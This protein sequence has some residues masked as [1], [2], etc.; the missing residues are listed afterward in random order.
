LDVKKIRT[1]IVIYPGLFTNIENAMRFPG[2]RFSG[3]CVF[4]VIAMKGKGFLL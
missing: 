4:R 1:N 2:T 3:S